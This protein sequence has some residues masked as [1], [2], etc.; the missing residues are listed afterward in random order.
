[1]KKLLRSSQKQNA[2]F[3]ELYSLKE[4]FLFLLNGRVFTFPMDLL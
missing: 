1:M 3:K 4:A 2:S